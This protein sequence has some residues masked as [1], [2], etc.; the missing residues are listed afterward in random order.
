MINSRELKELLP[1]TAKKAQAFIDACKA[2]GINLLVTS[3][4]RD[5]ESQDALYAQGRTVLGKR[6]TDAKGGD[7][8]HN[9]RVALDVVP[10]VNGA[11]VWDDQALWARIGSIGTGCGL[12]WGG[13]WIAPHR[14]DKPHFQDPNGFTLNDYKAGRA[15]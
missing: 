13:N 15:T 2:A 14:T 4:Y 3:T 7:S 11:C 8:F 10:L 5:K 6:V 9:Y 1:R 12:E